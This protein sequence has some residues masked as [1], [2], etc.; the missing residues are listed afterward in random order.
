[1]EMNGSYKAVEMSTA[2]VFRVVERPISEAGGW[3]N[4]PRIEA[5]GVCHSDLVTIQGD[6]PGLKLPRVPGH[7][8]GRIEE[9]FELGIWIRSKPKSSAANR[10]SFWIW[11]NWISSI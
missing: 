7:E 2:G 4:F 3:T 1:M 8:V 10:Q 11:R 9:N 6:D 5:F